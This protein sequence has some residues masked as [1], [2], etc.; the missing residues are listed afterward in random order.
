MTCITQQMKKFAGMSKAALEQ[1]EKT[2]KREKA[3]IL[4]IGVVML[5][6]GIYLLTVDPVY[7]A[8]LGGMS[9]SMIALADEA[10]KKLKTV[11]NLLQQ[12]DK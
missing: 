9:G 7:T 8:M 3:T 12:K 6:A 1:K 5:A 11:Q 10:G 4:S 2:F